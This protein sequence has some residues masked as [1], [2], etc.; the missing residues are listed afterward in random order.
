MLDKYICFKITLV[1]Q[2]IFSGGNAILRYRSEGI[3]IVNEISLWKK[4]ATT[5]NQEGNECRL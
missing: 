4:V 2:T 1:L 3:K 5:T